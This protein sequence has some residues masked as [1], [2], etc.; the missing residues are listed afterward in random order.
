MK[1]AKVDEYCQFLSNKRHRRQMSKRF[2][3]PRMISA[4]RIEDSKHVYMFSKQVIYPCSKVTNEKVCF[5]S[6]RY[7]CRWLSVY[8]IESARIRG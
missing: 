4:I 3:F 8:L 1:L 6:Q 2:T 5:Q 7:V